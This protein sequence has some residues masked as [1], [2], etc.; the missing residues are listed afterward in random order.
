MRR[1]HYEALIETTLQVVPKVRPG[2]GCSLKYPMA[3][4][5]FFVY[6]KANMKIRNTSALIIF[7]HGIP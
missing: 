2:F 4:Y 6:L 7:L 5:P 1:T 3:N